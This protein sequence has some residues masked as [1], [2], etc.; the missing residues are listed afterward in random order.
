MPE[1][2]KRKEKIKILKNYKKEDIGR[3]HALQLWLAVDYFVTVMFLRMR[4]ARAVHF[5]GV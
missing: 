5:R 2:K 4:P 1:K 3:F